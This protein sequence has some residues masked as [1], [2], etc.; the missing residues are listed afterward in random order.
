[1]LVFVGSVYVEINFIPERTGEQLESTL[2]QLS[3][4]RPPS[5]LMWWGK[6]AL[7]GCGL[8]GTGSG[9]HARVASSLGDDVALA[10]AV[11]VLLLLATS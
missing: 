11:L 5:P 9:S 8:W 4:E 7:D 1:M 3:L 6:A 2:R 10:T